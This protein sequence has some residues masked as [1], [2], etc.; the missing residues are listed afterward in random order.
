MVMGLYVSLTCECGYSFKGGYGNLADGGYVDLY[1]CKNCKTIFDES[2]K[3]I[4]HQC[5]QQAT[6]VELGEPSDWYWFLKKWWLT[7]KESVATIRCPKCNQ[8]RDLY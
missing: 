8:T 7:K 1:V 2:G 5:G 6:P 4:C 3:G